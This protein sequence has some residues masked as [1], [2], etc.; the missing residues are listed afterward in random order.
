MEFV[1]KNTDKKLIELNNSMRSKLKKEYRLTVFN[2]ITTEQFTKKMISNA[3]PLLK[4][5]AISDVLANL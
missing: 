2:I 1:I 4:K 5:I 3:D